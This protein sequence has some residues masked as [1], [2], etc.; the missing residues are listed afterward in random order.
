MRKTYLIT[1]LVL[2]AV[3]LFGC[4][5]TDAARENAYP[6]EIALEGSTGL[7][8]AEPTEESSFSAGSELF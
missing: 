2:I 7:Q 5:K 1:V 8:T 6:I 3:T 4:T